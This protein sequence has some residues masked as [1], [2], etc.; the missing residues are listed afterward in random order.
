MSEAPIFIT[1]AVL[2]VLCE[3]WDRQCGIV[4]RDCSIENDCSIYVQPGKVVILLTGR[5]AGKKAVIVKNNDDGTTGRPYGHAIVA[6][7]AKEPRKVTLGLSSCLCS[8]SRMHRLCSQQIFLVLKPG[9]LMQV[10][11][12]SSIKKQEKRSKVKVSSSFL[13]WLPFP[14]AIA[15]ACPCVS[16]AGSAYFWLQCLLM[17]CMSLCPASNSMRFPAD[18]PQGRQLPASDAH[19]VYPGCGPEVS[20]HT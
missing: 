5:Y 9:S 4:Q 17:E 15:G 20:R 19:A 6:G 1:E 8:L 18:V 14:S 3:A 7:L 2:T 11:K 13:L 12:R 10:I 16:Q